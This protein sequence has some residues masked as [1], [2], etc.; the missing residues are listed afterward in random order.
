[1]NTAEF[2]DISAAVVPD[3]AALITGDQQQ[4]FAEMG[5]Q[6]TQLANALQG[7]GLVK[8]D[9][10]GVMSVNSSEYVVTYYACARLGLTF[11]P[12]NYRAKAEELENMIN[13]AEVKALFVSDRYQEVVDAIRAQDAQRRARYLA[14][15]ASRRASRISRT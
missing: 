12:L 8:G 13:T 11:V 14:G 7:L 1:M 9:H 5:A 6:V 15:D 10:L 3:R 4:T 2:L